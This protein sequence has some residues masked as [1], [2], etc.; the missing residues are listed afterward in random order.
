MM[1]ECVK[2]E[3]QRNNTGKA[4]AEVA[5]NAKREAQREVDRTPAAD[6]SAAPKAPATPSGS[7]HAA[8]SRDVSGQ[9]S[10]PPLR[11]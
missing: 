2:L 1:R 3:Q 5:C 7:G 9:T 10:A 11:K 6:S 8:N 4:A